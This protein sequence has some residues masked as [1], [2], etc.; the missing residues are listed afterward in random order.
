MEL[1]HCLRGW[2]RGC[3]RDDNSWAVSLIVARLWPHYLR[4]NRSV[5]CFV[6]DAR[7]SP[8]VYSDFTGHVLG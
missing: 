2:T 3:H 4:K 5:A 7:L 6:I 8:A 1:K